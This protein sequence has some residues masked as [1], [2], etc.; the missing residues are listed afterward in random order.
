MNKSELIKNMATDLDNETAAGIALDSLLKALTDALKAGQSVTL[1]G[2]G[3]FKAVPRPARTGRNPQTGE[4]IR[5]AATTTCK[6]T[7]GKNLKAAVNQ[8]PE[9]TMTATYH[10]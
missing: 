10:G 9:S 6:F 2:F 4:A 1:Q 3:T 5:I 8:V 7:A